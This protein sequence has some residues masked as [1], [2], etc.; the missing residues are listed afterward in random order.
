[1]SNSIQNCNFIYNKFVSIKLVIY[2]FVYSLK[3]SNNKVYLVSQ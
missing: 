2:R 3:Y 1:M